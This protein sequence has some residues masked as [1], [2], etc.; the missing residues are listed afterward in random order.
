MRKNF[1]V[2]TAI[3]LTLGSQAQLKMLKDKVLGEKNPVAG[4]IKKPSP[5]TTNFEDDAVMDGALPESF[6]NDKQYIPLY[7]MPADEDGGF[8]LCPGYYEMT[9]MSYCLKAGTHGPSE[10]DGY[11]FAPTK[12]KMDDIVNAILVNHATKHTEVPQR[13]VQML[14]WAII[15]KAKFKN[16][17]GRLKVVSS[18]LLTP[19]QLVKLNGGYVETLG[20]TALNKGLID[21]PPAVQKVMEAENN[22]RRL[23][24]T[25]VENYEEFER[26]AILAGAANADRADVKRGM[27][28]LHPKGYYVRYYPSGYSRTKV[29]IYV[30]EKRGA[31]VYNAVGTIACPANTGS[32]RLA[33]TNLPIEKS[34]QEFINPCK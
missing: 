19:D 2:L 23:V 10:G 16:L 9:N 22:I 11:M 6:G 17:S 3:V 15:A 32:Q 18:L 29:Q 33:Q 28:S 21:L 30:P 14:L 8:K 31:V 7:K 4:I 20:T 34:G 25:G 27:W 12:G 24:E 26:Y 13:E 1:L 5:I